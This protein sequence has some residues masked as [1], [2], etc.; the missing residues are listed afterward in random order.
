[1]MRNLRYLLVLVLS[2]G[3]TAHFGEAV[4]GHAAD[5]QDH[6]PGKIRLEVYKSPTC[7]CCAK[8]VEHAEAA[9]F[10]TA[11][12]HP[13]DLNRI[14]IDHAI[15]PRYQSC[16]TAVSEGGYVF[17]G[18]IP[19]RF[20]REFFKSPPKGAVGL[21]VPGMPAGS[22]GMEMGNRFSPY[23]ILLLK[24]NGESEVFAEVRSARE[25]YR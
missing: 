7:G 16:H 10:E 22:P 15:A 5:V 25:Q 14:K 3:M 12:H 18:H 1:M 6:S 4:S 2:L 13:Q 23:Q 20:I 24:A 11:V 21:A 19:A 9:G 8:W 17:E